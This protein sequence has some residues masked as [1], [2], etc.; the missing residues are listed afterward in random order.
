MPLPTL[1]KI[2]AG[3][4]PGNIP[5]FPDATIIHGFGEDPSP[6]R[7]DIRTSSNSTVYRSPT[8]GL[9]TSAAFN[10]TEEPPFTILGGTMIAN[11]RGLTGLKM[12]YMVGSQS[13]SPGSGDGKSV[14]FTLGGEEVIV[15]F[16][17]GRINMP[18]VHSL[19]GTD[20]ILLTL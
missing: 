4:K 3:D 1:P 12:S 9:A 16:K 6:D 18:G 14:S 2:K 13:R 19:P 11:D 10:E 15:G 8:F 17:G 7:H 20:S 5:G